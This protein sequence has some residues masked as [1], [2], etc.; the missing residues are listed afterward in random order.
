MTLA[1]K[2]AI[3]LCVVAVSL[4]FVVG[5]LELIVAATHL[6]TKSNTMFEPEIGPVY[7]PHA[8]YRHTKEGFSEGYFNAQG[9]RDYERTYQKSENTF[10]VIVLGD[11]YVEG[12]QVPLE[13]TFTAE[14]E[15]QLNQNFA[16]KKF[17]VLNLGQSGY[18][19]TDEYLRYIKFGVKYHPDLVILAF[20]T[21]NDFRNNSKVLNLGELGYYYSLNPQGQLVLDRSLIDEYEQSLTLPKRLFQYVKEKSY[22]ASLVSERIFLLRHQMK[23][24]ELQK[25]LPA[26]RPKGARETLSELSDYNIYRPEMSDRWKD[27]VAVTKAVL[28]KFKES[29]EAN[30]SEFLL[31]TLSNSEQ[32]DP[33]VQK[34]IT[35]TY[36]P[37]FDFDQPDR[38]IEQYASAEHIPYLKLMPAFREYRLR[39]GQHLHGWST[40]ETGHWNEVGHH[41]AAE[42]IFEFIKA[43]DLAS[44]REHELGRAASR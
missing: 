37:G 4:I 42:K 5:V 20:L 40:V 3:A 24:N 32:I 18:G 25:S 7:I 29:V 1:R 28:G 9:F 36:G 6:T 17:E 23:Y 34:D 14:L 27:A 31:V 22:L 39:T 10:R 15:K 21:G 38:I 26:D 12:L 16:P 8:Y 44:P 13:K 35:D 43:N 2:T 11:S 41:L 19:T 33:A 30:G